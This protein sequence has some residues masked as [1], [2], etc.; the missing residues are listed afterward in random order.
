MSKIKS[1]LVKETSKWVEYPDIDGF[2]V[3]LRYL[4][5]EDLLKIRNASLIIKFSKR[6]RQKEEEVDSAK[7][8]ENYADRAIAGWRGLKIKHLPMLVPVDI[9]GADGNAEVEYTPEDAVEMLKNSTAFDQFV[10]DALNDFEQFSRKK[11]E[12]DSKN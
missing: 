11:A 10:S 5:R 3:N 7:F 6:T 9:S 8:I 1:L 2:E 12:D 4:T